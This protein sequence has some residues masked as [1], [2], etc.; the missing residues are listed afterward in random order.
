MLFVTLLAIY[1][2]K[3]DP[4]GN[5]T[6]TNT[7]TVPPS[8]GN[9]PETIVKGTDPDNA[10]TQG[11]F[12]D[13]SWQAKTFVAPTTQDITKPPVSSITVSIDLSKVITKVSPYLFGNNTN[14]FMGQFV[15]QPVLMSNL[16][17]LSP[18]IL[19]FPGGSLSDIYFWNGTNQAPADAP[20]QL[21]DLNGTS[22]AAGY[23]YGNNTASWTFTLDNYYK[24]LQQVHSTGLITV[25]YGYARYGTGAH[26]DQAAA[27]LAADWVRYDKGRTKY[28]EIGNE[29]FG[30]WEA[31]YRIN[32]TNNHD[33]QPAMLT[34][35]LYGTHFKVFADS[36][37]AAAKETGATIQIGIVLTEA[38]DN[39]GGWNAGVLAAAGNSA[40][41]FVVHNYYTPYQQ[42]STPDV[43]LSTPVPVT[44]STMD[45]VKSSVQGAGVTQKPVAMDE[46]NITSI[47]SNQMVS[48][49]AGVHGVMVLGEMLKNQFS[50]GARWD[51]ANAWDKGD[52]M[53]MFNNQSDPSNIEPGA[54]AWNARPAF[55]YMYYF[56]KYFG[57]RMVASTVNGSSDILSY[58]SSF[59]SGQAGDILVNKSSN[60]HTVILSISNFL[61][62]TKY[63]FYVLKGGV[64]AL[65]SR[66][67]NINGNVTS[68]VSGGPDNF[69]SIPAN[70]AAIQGGITVDV[71]AYGVVY[72]VADKS[73]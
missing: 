14:P 60:D 34:P 10:L 43:I 4:A 62:G 6:T 73:N 15:D 59:T 33:G 1:S 25:N 39:I 69:I 37:R 12:L 64:D 8:T 56:Q 2:C 35:D 11:F 68:A 54:P 22:S 55:Y 57:D 24:V 46:Y 47:G 9:T 7:N 45:W 16:T 23:W 48:Q 20:P 17:T 58:A 53:G 38:N 29:N 49:I 66:K 72:L 27:H 41:F 65:F 13:N 52:D 32:T 40:D 71:P 18:N 70:S 50:M 5:K 28:W 63:Y 21:L 31:G 3:K 67:V 42:N 61:P 51:L 26:P 36:M 19:R 44:K 30:T